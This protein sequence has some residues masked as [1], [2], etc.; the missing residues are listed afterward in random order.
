MLAAEGHYFVCPL[1]MGYIL[2]HQVILDFRGLFLPENRVLQDT[3]EWGS[4]IYIPLD[5][6]SKKKV[7]K[8]GVKKVTEGKKVMK[9]NQSTEKSK[10]TQK[11]TKKSNELKKR[12]Q[13]I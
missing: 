11:I 6:K 4:S 9:L 3:S 5:Q 13:Q 10:F 7:L 8:K 2:Y 1:N 12:T